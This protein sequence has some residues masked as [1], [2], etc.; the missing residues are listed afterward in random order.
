MTMASTAAFCNRSGLFVLVSSL[1]CLSACRT[2]PATPAPSISVDTWATVDGRTITRNDV[3]KAFRRQSDPSQVMS[4]EEALTA[5]LNLLNDLIVQDILIAK[6]AQL[7][8][9]VP[10]DRARYRVRRREEEHLGRG[11]PER[12]G[13]PEPVA[14]GNA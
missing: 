8:I 1:L 5:K 2:A 14:G 9:E 11:V 6:A 4:D 3:D 13:T 7:K 10:A 12:A